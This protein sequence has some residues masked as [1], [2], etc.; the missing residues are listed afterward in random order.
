VTDGTTNASVPKGTAVESVTLTD[1]L[2]LIAARAGA[3][4]R[5]GGRGRARTSKGKK[6]KK[7]AEARA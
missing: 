2:D 5:K 4:R 7:A 6:E 3:P 1:A